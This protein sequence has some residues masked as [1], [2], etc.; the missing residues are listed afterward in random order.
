MALAAISVNNDS[1]TPSLKATTE[2]A[3]AV[4]IADEAAAK[5]GD[6]SEVT[7]LG[8]AHLSSLPK[9][10]EMRR[11]A[12]L[13]DKLAAWK[14]E[15]IAI[16]GLTGAQCDY[17]KEYRFYDPDTLNSLCRDPS[18]ARAALGLDGAAAEAEIR[19]ILATS[20]VDRPA[21]QRRRLAVL[22][23]A[24]GE[25]ASAL[26]QWLRLP[27]PDRRTDDVLSNALADVLTML[28]T[29]RNENYVIAA[30]LAVRLGH[31][32]VYSV[33]DQ[34]AGRRAD[35]IDDKLYEQE[36]SAIWKNVAASERRG[37]EEGWAKRIS[38]GGDVLAW[39]RWLNS[40]EA[41][42]LAVAGDF[43][44]AAGAKVPGN[45]GRK[46][47]AYWETRNMRMVANIR[48]AVGPGTRLL[49]IVGASH[50]PYYE[51]YLGVSSDIGIVDVQ[52]ILR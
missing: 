50:K 5:R 28:E 32:R 47:L 46:Y 39:Y 52:T 11:L 17:L 3:T 26:V 38:E 15:K 7:V 6:L 43:G 37:L 42:R 49:A 16:E 19:S 14:P 13:I 44:A 30:R 35:P 9:D 24:T 21:S 33:D 18:V 34:T 40:P 12:R 2:I 36:I 10:F 20:G 27:A 51:R 1:S 31:E 25:P 8:T 45:S 29:R 4:A 23:L 22:F 41:G 48:E